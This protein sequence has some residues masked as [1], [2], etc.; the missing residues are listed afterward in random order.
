[1]SRA[2]IFTLIGETR[3]D[4]EI[5]DVL[6]A[7]RAVIR[8]ASMLCDDE[9]DVMQALLRASAALADAHHALERRRVSP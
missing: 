6:E 1:M 3:K 5:S 9:D 4:R 2:E 7:R 8:A